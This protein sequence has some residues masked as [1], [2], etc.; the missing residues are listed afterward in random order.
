MSIKPKD[1]SY[2]ETFIAD[3]CAQRLRRLAR[4][5]AMGM[6]TTDRKLKAEI[7]NEIRQMLGMDAEEPKK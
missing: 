5:F 2:G 4:L 7:A 1:D 3:A 6:T